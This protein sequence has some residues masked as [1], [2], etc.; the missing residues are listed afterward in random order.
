MPNH[1]HGIITITQSCQDIGVTSHASVDE[2]TPRVPT[3]ERF[4]IPISGSLPT[5]IRSFKSS[6]TLRY[7]LQ[8]GNPEITLWQHNYYEHIVRDEI[9]LNRIREYINNNPVNWMLDKEYFQKQ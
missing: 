8:T 2:S 7:R 6:T 9:D 4:G 5:I 1:L 3:T